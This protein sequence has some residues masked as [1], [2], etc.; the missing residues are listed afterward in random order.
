MATKQTKS[1][2]DKKVSV[3]TKQVPAKAPAPAKKAEVKPTPVK[4]PTKPVAVAKPKAVAKPAPAKNLEAKVALGKKIVK[5][6]TKAVDIVTKKDGAKAAAP[7]KKAVQKLDKTITS[8]EQKKPVAAKPVKA[9]QGIKSVPGKKVVPSKAFVKTV[10]IGTVKTLK[11]E[12]A[13]Q[14]KQKPA[15]DKKVVNALSTGLKAPRPKA[16]NKDTAT[17]ATSVDSKAFTATYVP[18]APAPAPAPIPTAAAL[19][20]QAAAV[21]PASAPREMNS[22]QARAR[23]EMLRRNF[24]ML[25]SGAPR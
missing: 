23:E 17:S 14:P 7:L 18:V 19:A 3:P 16:T 24:S 2:T 15:S 9:V 11:A 13:F 20:Q 6:T 21:R 8:I 22:D 1:V 12:Q 10:K 5:T 4:A 25:Q